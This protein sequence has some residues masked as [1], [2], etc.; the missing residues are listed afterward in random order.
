MIAWVDIHGWSIQNSL[1]NSSCARGLSY[2]DSFEFG[3]DLLVDEVRFEE[4]IWTTNVAL[5]SVPV[6]PYS[7]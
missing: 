7:A 2:I 1:Q 5:D 3:I 4:R 6:I